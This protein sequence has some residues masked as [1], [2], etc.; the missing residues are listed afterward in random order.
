MREKLE[1]LR[2]DMYEYAKYLE[3][4]TYQPYEDIMIFAI[5]LRKILENGNE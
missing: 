5:R 3:E 1:Q 4:E 2:K